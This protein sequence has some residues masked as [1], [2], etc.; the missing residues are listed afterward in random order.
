MPI[1]LTRFGLGEMLRCCLEIRRVARNEPTME[2]T[3]RRV[4]GFFYDELTTPEGARA[5]A[6]VR[7]Y[8]THAYG[9]LPDDLRRFAKRA[10]RSNEAEVELTDSMRCLTLLA[11]VGDDPSWN[12][13]HLSKGHQ[14]VPLPSPQIVQRAPMIAQLI[15]E[16]GLALSD[17]VQP[18]PD[19][20]RKL[21]GK[22]YGVFHVA[23]ASGSPYIPAQAQ[24]VERHAIR[25]VL[26]FG[27]SLAGGDLFAVILFT[28]TLISND[29]A[30]RFR[31]VALD[32]KGCLV[33]FAEDE[34]FEPGPTA[35]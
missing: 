4:C 22:T 26:G 6:L 31:T 7:C 3:A 1:D 5:C 20:M 35:R 25:S 29:I 15:H 17:V 13:R 23:E 8:K 27:G 33:P 12:E 18:S 32:V 30:D 28:R 34:V 2:A 9:H 24:F 19:V 11:T 16:F 21:E 10:L 14:A